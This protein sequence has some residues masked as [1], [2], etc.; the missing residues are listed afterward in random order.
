MNAQ[1]I[2]FLKMVHATDNPEEMAVHIKTLRD[3]GKISQKVYA[4][5]MHLMK[6]PTEEEIQE[7]SEYLK[8]LQAEYEGKEE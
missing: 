7:A 3:E 2:A 8:Q 6:L 5:G 4:A 1:E